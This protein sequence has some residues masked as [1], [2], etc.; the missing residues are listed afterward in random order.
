MEMEPGRHKIKPTGR[1]VKAIKREVRACIRFT[2]PEYLII[3]EKAL[4]VGMKPSAYLR[5]LG[6]HTII[7]TRLTPEEREIARNLIGMANN[8]NQFIKCCHVEGVPLAAFRF[9]NLTTILDEMLE[10]LKP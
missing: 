2:H 10:K 1:P 5:H 8:L 9:H 3:K 6:I 4:K 7:N